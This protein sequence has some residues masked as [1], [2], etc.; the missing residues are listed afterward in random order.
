MPVRAK[1]NLQRLIYLRLI[2]VRQD[3]TNC[4]MPQSSLCVTVDCVCDSV[5]PAP[6]QDNGQVLLLP[7]PA[8]AVLTAAVMNECDSRIHLL[9]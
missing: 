5:K 1:V 3:L 9:A 6:G 2:G 8:V 7:A 4:R